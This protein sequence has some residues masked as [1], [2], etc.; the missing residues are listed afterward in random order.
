VLN[1]WQIRSNSE[2][3]G[4]DIGNI[5]AASRVTHIQPCVRCSIVHIHPLRYQDMLYPCRPGGGI[6]LKLLLV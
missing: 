5:K 6:S 4:P 3:G 1:D 2:A